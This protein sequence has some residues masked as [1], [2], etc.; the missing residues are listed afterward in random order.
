MKKRLFF[1]AGLVV[2]I[3]MMVLSCFQKNGTLK[4]KSATE[5]ISYNF[6]VRPILSDKCFACHGPDSKKRE[7]GL[8]L[9]MAESAYGKLKDGNGVAIFP[10]SPEKSEL[11]KRITSVD[12]EY[13]MPTPESHLGLL[14]ESEVETIKTWIE[15]GGKYEKHWAF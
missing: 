6:N 15:Q 2:A 9:D 11:Y 10:G 4:R 8:R 7:A 12:P 1:S 5:A 3:G 14:N 13:Q